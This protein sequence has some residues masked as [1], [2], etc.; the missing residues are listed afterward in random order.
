MRRLSFIVL[1]LMSIG[2]AGYAVVAYSVLPLGSTVHPDMRSVF[3]DHK[4]GIYAH[5]FGSAI[6]LCLGPLQFSTRLRTDYIAF[7]RW[8]GRLYLIA[9]I[10]VGGVSGLYMSIHA[11]GGVMA[12]TGF[13]ALGLLWLYTGLRAYMA[14]RIRDIA[15]HRRWMIRNF[16]LTFAAVTLRIYLP[17][18]M[19][20]GLEF[21]IVY[22][23][24]AWLCWLP[25]LIVAEF[26]FI[27]SP[28][29]GLQ[30]A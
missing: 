30:R 28:N 16:A 25:N 7:H 21:G 27:R 11:Y 6:A 17:G 1:Y 23:I 22:P 8:L 9:G 5:I 18:S 20:A 26:I 15:S 14:I 13:A 2:V 3:Q 12:K 24:I 10:L 19:A 4:L 29:N